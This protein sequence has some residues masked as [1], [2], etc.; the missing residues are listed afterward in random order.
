MRLGNESDSA[1]IVYGSWDSKSI[2]Q[3]QDCVFHADSNLYFD[4]TVPDDSKRFG[5]GLTVSVRYINFRYDETTNQCIDYVR[6]IF[7]GGHKLDKICG[8]FN[9]ESEIGQQSFF[10][11]PP[12]VVKVHIFVDKSKPLPVSQTSVSL[13][14]VFTAYQSMLH[15]SFWWFIL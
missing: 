4:A 1:K 10:T 12:G 15:V 9:D 8:T 2:E 6:L 11:V 3:F 14:L 7:P 13:E 5:R